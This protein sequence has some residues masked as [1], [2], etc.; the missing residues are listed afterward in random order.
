MVGSNSGLQIFTSAKQ[1]GG[2]LTAKV[3]ISTH[4]ERHGAPRAAACAQ[5]Q[6]PLMHDQRYCVECGARRGPL[7]PTAAKLIAGLHSGLS[8]SD[9]LLGA[10]DSADASSFDE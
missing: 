1:I 5:C 3:A 7:S 2:R 6:A 4:D 10:M 9:G 8:G